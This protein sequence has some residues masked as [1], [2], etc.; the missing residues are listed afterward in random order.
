MNL[1]ADVEDFV[2]L[3]RGQ[4]TAHGDAGELTPSGYLLEIA[5]RCGVTFERWVTQ[6]DAIDDLLRD[7]LRAERN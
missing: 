3:H 6:L 4:R 7:H 5:C 1:A 2:A